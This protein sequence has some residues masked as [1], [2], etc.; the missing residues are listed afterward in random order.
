MNR[1]AKPSNFAS[2]LRTPLLREH[3]V[4]RAFDHSGRLIYIGCTNNP[5]NRLREHRSQSQWYRHVARVTLAGPFNY[6]TARQVEYDAIESERSLHN[7]ST[8]RRELHRLRDRLIDFCIQRSIDEG[9]PF[10]EALAAG[11]QLG[12]SLLPDGD[13]GSALEVD[14]TTVPRARRF[15]TEYMST[16]RASA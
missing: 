16:E 2:R 3:F 1:Y 5:A 14:D 8:E 4:Y 6:E 15:V 7:Y 12:D 13:A 9:L 11:V 10:A